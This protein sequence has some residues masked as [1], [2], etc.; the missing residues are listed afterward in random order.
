VR[1]STGECNLTVPVFTEGTQRRG[2]HL[3]PGDRKGREFVGGTT[4]KKGGGRVNHGMRAC[5]NAMPTKEFA[6]K[7][8]TELERKFEGG[9]YKKQPEWAKPPTRKGSNDG[10][11]LKKVK[12]KRR[13]KQ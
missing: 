2:A 10:Q 4:R 6:L 11:W 12:S 13:R 8:K 3:T 9:G 7:Q 1:H 5:D